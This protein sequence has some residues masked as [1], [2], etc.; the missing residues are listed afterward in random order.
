MSVD[1]DIDP[2]LDLWGFTASDL[3]SN[4]VIG[5]D[6]ITGTLHFI[7][8]YSSAFVAPEDSGNYL[9]IHCEVPEV[10]GV[11]ITVEVVNGTSGPVTLDADGTIVLR[12]ADKSLQ[13]V[14]VVASKSGYDPVTKEFD[15][16]G[17][18]CEAE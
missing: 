16:T 9:C 15:L 18:T 10:E 8:D 17:L 2:T 7:D 1:A 4:I 3:Q 6:A 12:I 14:E 5:D 13:T 11:T